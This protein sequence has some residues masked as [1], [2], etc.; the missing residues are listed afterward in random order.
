MGSSLPTS[1]TMASFLAFIL[2][3]VLYE[4]FC[5]VGSVSA[6]PQGEEKCVCGVSG[7]VESNRIVNGTDALDGEIPWQVFVASYN[8]IDRM[9]EVCGGTVVT[10]RHVVTAAHCTY[11]YQASN[12][13]A[14]YGIIYQP[15]TWKNLN[16]ARFA[17]AEKIEHPQYE[18][19]SVKNDIAVLVLQNRI[20][21]AENPTVRPACLP[22]LGQ[23]IEE[24]IGQTAV[25]SG[26]G[27]LY[28]N[29]PP[30]WKT[31]VSPPCTAWLAGVLSGMAA[32]GGTTRQ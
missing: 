20:D 30:P 25:V 12:I 1:G 14:I 28:L 15:F 29:G 7:P 22:Q 11:G 13:A 8:P 32:L 24:V 31:T 6:A 17:V 9:Y 10:D 18:R 21:W 3:T 26:W 27:D 23:T 16:D 19:V 2:I 4:S 5:S